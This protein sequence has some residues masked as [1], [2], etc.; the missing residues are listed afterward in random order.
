MWIVA[1]VCCGIFV[2]VVAAFIYFGVKRGKHA[3]ET[4]KKL[5]AVKMSATAET[6]KIKKVVKTG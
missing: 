4:A 5:Q 1:G 2:L 3:M 6:E